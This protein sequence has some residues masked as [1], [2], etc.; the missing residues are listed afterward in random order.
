MKRILIVD[1][2]PDILFVLKTVLKVA[3]Y[4]VVEAASGEEAIA[5]LESTDTPDATLLDIRLPGIDGWE[6]LAKMR[7]VSWLSRSPVIVISAHAEADSSARAAESGAS[8][9]ITKPFDP[10]AVTRELERVLQAA[11]G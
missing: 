8:A 7:E 10:T 2:E 3:G 5:V 1:D 9:Y 4:E 11:A 6:V